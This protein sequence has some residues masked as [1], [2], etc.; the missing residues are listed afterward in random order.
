[1]CAIC[2]GIVTGASIYFIKSYI[3]SFDDSVC[4]TKCAV[5]G[6]SYY[7]NIGVGVGAFISKCLM[8]HFLFENYD[9]ILSYF[10]YKK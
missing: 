7:F 6:S 1:M 5:P 4:L 9:F 3:L 10:F 2:V 8:L